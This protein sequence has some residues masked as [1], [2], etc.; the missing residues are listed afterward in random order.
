MCNFE[1]TFIRIEFNITNILNLNHIIILY[2]VHF[3]QN[4]IFFITSDQFHNIYSSKQQ[5]ET[6]NKYKPKNLIKIII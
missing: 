5:I 1:M 4:E 3:S 2:N 6:A